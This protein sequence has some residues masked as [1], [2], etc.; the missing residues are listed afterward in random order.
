MHSNNVNS[1]SEDLPL[2]KQVNQAVEAGYDPIPQHYVQSV[3]LQEK[4]EQYTTGP[5][6]NA[7]VHKIMNYDVSLVEHRLDDEQM[8]AVSMRCTL[9]HDLIP[10]VHHAEVEKIVYGYSRDEGIV[11]ADPEDIEAIIT[12]LKMKSVKEHEETLFLSIE[13]LDDS[14][15][16]ATE[17]VHGCTLAIRIFLKGGTVVETHS[18][19]RDKDWNPEVGALFMN[20]IDLGRTSFTGERNP[21]HL[22]D[23]LD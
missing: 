6:T 15:V 21:D 22:L 4:R 11:I 8:Y 5:F 17:H 13:D 16:I 3:E 12:C 18:H 20:A 10:T 19:L 2:I 14:F 7:V 23:E 1:T 9:P